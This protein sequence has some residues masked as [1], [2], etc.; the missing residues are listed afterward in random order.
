MSVYS[1]P[2]TYLSAFCKPFYG[3]PGCVHTHPN[4]GSAR[5]TQPST[6]PRMQRL[7]DRQLSCQVIIINGDGKC[8][9][10]GVTDQVGWLVWR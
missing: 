6:N 2:Q 5:S 9:I 8:G 3:V 7:N 4:Y 1:R 10:Y